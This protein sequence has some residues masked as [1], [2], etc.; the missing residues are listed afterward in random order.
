VQV[1]NW[2]MR[3][4]SASQIQYASLDAHCMLAIL[5]RISAD[6]NFSACLTGAA[7]RYSV[8][9]EVVVD[10]STSIYSDNASGAM[11][12]TDQADTTI[13]VQPGNDDWRAYL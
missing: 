13:H 3:P 10:T 1:S 11:V 7:D 9:A 8:T 6:M 4:L 12:V 5:D 2:D